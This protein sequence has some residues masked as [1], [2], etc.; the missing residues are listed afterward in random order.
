MRAARQQTA[1]CR[2]P[3]LPP[4]SGA[5]NRNPAAS[6]SASARK[7]RLGCFSGD[8]EAPRNN[9][10][11]R[12]LSLRAWSGGGFCRDRIAIVR[13]L[14]SEPAEY[15]DGAADARHVC[16]GVATHPAIPRSKLRTKHGAHREHRARGE[17]DVEAEAR[18]ALSLRREEVVGL[19]G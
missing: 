8:F 15:A 9:C 4:V 16:E 11:P 7:N 17:E 6:S 14:P 2:T 12:G 18:R 3:E 13:R 1:S 5:R 10:G 19:D